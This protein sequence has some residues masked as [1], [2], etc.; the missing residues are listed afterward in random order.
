M[1]HNTET[2]CIKNN[3]TPHFDEDRITCHLRKKCGQNLLTWHQQGKEL[4]ALECFINSQKISKSN[5]QFHVH[6]SVSPHGT[7]HIPLDGFS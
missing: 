6:L 1:L 7:T 2:A 4:T 5:Y 3:K